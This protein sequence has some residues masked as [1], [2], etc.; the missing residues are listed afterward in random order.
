MEVME[1]KIERLKA[2]LE[3]SSYTVMI[4]GSGI[5]AEGGYQGLKTPER[6]YET[7]KKYGLSPENL[8]TTIFYNNRTAQFF[9]FYRSQVLEH[10]PQ[11]TESSY[12]AARMEQ[13][14]KLQCIIDSN[15]YEL[16]QKGGCKNVISLHGSIYKNKCP[17]CGREYSMEYIR[18]SKKIPRCES[19]GRVIRPGVM[20]FGEMMDS[21]LMSE[22]TRQ[23]ERADVLLLLGTGMNSEVFSKY[24]RYF[25]GR[26]LVIIHKESKLMDEKADLVILDE[27][28]NVLP[29]LGY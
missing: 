8:F 28:K 21:G 17:H 11:V 9:D 6:A 12:T 1:R 3:E 14:G 23:I 7:E 25:H 5:M 26:K 19:C 10:Q 27:P 24:V 13:A 4:T 22:A 2:I 20:L 18:D 29:K 16:P 15:I